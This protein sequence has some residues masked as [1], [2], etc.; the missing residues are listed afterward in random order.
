MNNREQ[1]EQSVISASAYNGNDTEG[2]LKEIEDVYKK[3]RA[4]D[5]IL[6]G[7]PNAMQDALKED[8]G[9]D[10]AVGIMT[11]QVVYK[12]EEEQENEY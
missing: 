12:Y 8:I 10:E 1:I 5:E 2:L 7:L 4:F 6:E 3:A 11:G 9:L